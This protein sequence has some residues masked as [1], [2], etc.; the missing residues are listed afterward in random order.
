MSHEPTAH[1]DEFAGKQVSTLKEYCNLMYV[2]R[3]EVTAGAFNPSRA[4]SILTA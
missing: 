3:S 4:G 2:M 1:P